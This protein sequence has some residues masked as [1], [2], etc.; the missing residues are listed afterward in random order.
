MV[1]AFRGGTAYGQ[2]HYGQGTGRITLDHVGCTG[3]ESTITACSNSGWLVHA[4]G[5]YEDAGV[6]CT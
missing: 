3:S 4:C 6:S 5:H 1:S 2:A